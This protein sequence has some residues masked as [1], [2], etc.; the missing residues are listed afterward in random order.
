MISIV[1]HSSSSCAS[2]SA[3]AI[4][5]KKTKKKQGWRD[6]GKGKGTLGVFLRFEVRL[7]NASI[8]PVV[9]IHPFIYI[10]PSVH[11]LRSSLRECFGSSINDK[12][13]LNR[14][15]TFRLRR[16]TSKKDVQLI[17]IWATPVL[18]PS[19]S[20]SIIHGIIF[21]F[22]KISSLRNLVLMS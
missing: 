7:M 17:R 3:F 6:G 8:H 14:R 19:I 12:S 13:F 18:F 10:H 1:T 15:K 20:S 21:N 22:T 5:R 4:L 11:L 16:G 9:F 2:L